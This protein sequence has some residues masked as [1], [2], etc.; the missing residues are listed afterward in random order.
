MCP[1]PQIYQKAVKFLTRAYPLSV[2]SAFRH[3]HIPGRC[4]QSPL[5]S[6][7]LH[8]QTLPLSCKGC[9]FLFLRPSKLF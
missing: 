4:F 8:L 9:D 1:T 5:L 6:P 3:S 7:F 2:S